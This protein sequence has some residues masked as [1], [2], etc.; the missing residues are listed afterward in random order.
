MPRAKAAAAGDTPKDTWFFVLVV[1]FHLVSHCSLAIGVGMKGEIKRIAYQ[2]RQRVQFLSHET[3]LLPPPR[4][5]T[6]HKVE[7]ETERDEGE[8]PVQVGVVCRV[9]LHAV[10]EGGEHGHDAAEAYGIINI[11]VIYLSIC[12]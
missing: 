11:N 3:G 8:G 12:L 7:E 6:I 4:D 2:V 10:A 5:F 9:V 1:G